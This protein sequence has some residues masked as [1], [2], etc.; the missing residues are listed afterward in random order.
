MVKVV[1][2]CEGGLVQGVFTD[3]SKEVD[4]EVF[5]LDEPGF[6]TKKEEAELNKRREEYN[7]AIHEL[8]QIY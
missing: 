4:V 2:V 8:E 6:M 7:A 1:V 5:D 3:K